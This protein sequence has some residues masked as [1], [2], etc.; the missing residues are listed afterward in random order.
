MRNYP[1]VTV[2]KVQDSQVKGGIIKIHKLAMSSLVLKIRLVTKISQC[3]M[4]LQLRNHCSWVGLGKVLNKCGSY[5]G[6][7]MSSD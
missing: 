4:V 6:L 3:W 2:S 5:T 7:V 1:L